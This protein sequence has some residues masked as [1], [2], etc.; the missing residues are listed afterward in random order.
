MKKLLGLLVL[1]FLVVLYACQK[2][3]GPTQEEFDKLQK[4][5]ADKDAKIAQLENDMQLMKADFDKCTAERDSLMALTTKKAAVK[6]Q[7]TKPT[8]TT[9]QTKP[10]TRTEL[11]GQTQPKTDQTTEGG[12][13]SLKKGQ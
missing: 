5:L 6:P 2:P 1:S 13:A 10:D 11:K 7:T 9:Q 3:Q 12:R 8:T 4:E